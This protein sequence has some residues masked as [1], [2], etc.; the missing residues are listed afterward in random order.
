MEFWTNCILKRDSDCCAGEN[1]FFS[2]MPIV[3]CRQ[4]QTSHTY[5]LQSRYALMHGSCVDF[6]FMNP[7]VTRSFN[8]TA[9]IQSVFKQIFLLN[10]SFFGSYSF[11]LTIVQITQLHLYDPLPWQQFGVEISIRFN[12]L[13]NYFVTASMARSVISTAIQKELGTRTGDT[14]L[15]FLPRFLPA[16]ASA[17]C[18]SPAYWGVFDKIHESTV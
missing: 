11:W 1:S 4:W 17:S 18:P 3:F 8:T 16:F 13:L 7:C 5:E 9:S 14:K 6:Y 15:G 10:P 2:F 12:N